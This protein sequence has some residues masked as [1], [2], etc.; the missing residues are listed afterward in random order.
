MS[1]EQALVVLGE[2]QDGVVLAREALVG[3]KAA[4]AAAVRSGFDAG[5]RPSDM[6]GVLG[7]S[8]QW[9]Y[10]LRDSFDSDEQKT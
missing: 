9:V 6:A 10:E 8:R 3:A 1:R 7:S 2:A 4:L 5:C